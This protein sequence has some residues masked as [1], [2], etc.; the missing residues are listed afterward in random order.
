MR[1]LWDLADP[2]NP[3]PKDNDRV[4]LSYKG[5]SGVKALFNLITDNKVKTI[6]DLWKAL[7]ESTP[8]LP[9]GTPDVATLSAYGAIFAANG[10]SVGSLGMT[11][12]GV[13]KNTWTGN[14]QIPSFTWTIPVGFPT[15][16]QAA[17]QLLDQF[18][19]LIFDRTQNSY[20]QVLD[21]GTLSV[22]NGQLKVTGSNTVSWTPTK[23]QWEKIL[24]SGVADKTWVV[25]GS[26]R[27]SNQ[28]LKSTKFGI[29]EVTTEGITGPYWSDRSDF[30]VK[31]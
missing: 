11:I 5:F 12:K 17:G 13:V 6:N 27:Y 3:D 28:T 31:P 18:Q 8:T 19:I 2:K 20:K 22:S 24:E 25:L 23:Q 21:S 4:Q 16:T 15:A 30:T 29:N 1:I 7:V 9:D 10:A 14:D 26:D